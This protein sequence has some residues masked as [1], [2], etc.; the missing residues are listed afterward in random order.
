MTRREVPAASGRGQG[1]RPRAG[2]ADAVPPPAPEDPQSAG[3]SQAGPRP[4]R[5]Q[6]LPGHSPPVGEK[7]LDVCTE[8]SAWKS[9]IPESISGS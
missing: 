6:S 7:E 2:W 1:H 9:P 3:L 4:E 5:E 8:L